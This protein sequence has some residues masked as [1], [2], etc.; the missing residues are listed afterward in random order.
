LVGSGGTS[1]LDDIDDDAAVG[2]SH[3]QPQCRGRRILGGG[4]RSNQNQQ[5][6]GRL[7]R[8]MQPT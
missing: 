2:G 6:F 1:S 3:T 8:Q 4:K 7:C 5:G